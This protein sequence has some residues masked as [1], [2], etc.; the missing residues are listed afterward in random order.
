MLDKKKKTFN[1][2][3]MKNAILEKV[4]IIGNAFTSN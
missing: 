1:F 2:Q 4:S 3:M